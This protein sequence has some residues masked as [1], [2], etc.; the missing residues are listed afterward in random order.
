MILINC[1]NKIAPSDCLQY[2]TD[3]ASQIKSFN[4][5]DSTIANADKGIYT[6]TINDPTNSAP[7]LRTR[8]LANQKQNI[9]IRP[10]SV[11]LFSN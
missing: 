7:L 1:S 3:R 6:D 4:W 10:Q 2:F 11:R 8:Q 5:K 9:C